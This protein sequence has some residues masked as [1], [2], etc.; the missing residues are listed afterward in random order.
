MPFAKRAVVWPDTSDT[1][2]T[3]AGCEPRPLSERRRFP[4]QPVRTSPRAQG[5][6]AP[7][8]GVRGPGDEP[9]SPHR[10]HYPHRDNLQVPANVFFVP[11]EQFLVPAFWAMVRRSTN[12]TKV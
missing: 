4:R 12:S 1:W 6:T 5:P 2:A 9:N 8:T 3:V 7:E 10:R 11:L